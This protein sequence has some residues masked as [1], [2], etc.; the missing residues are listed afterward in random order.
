MAEQVRSSRGGARGTKAARWISRLR[1]L[2]AE[3]PELSASGKWNYV[4][5]PDGPP[6]LTLQGPDLPLLVAGQDA[7][8]VPPGEYQAW[9][10]L[11][12]QHEACR[13]SDDVESRFL[14][15]TNFR[16]AS[17]LSDPAKLIRDRCRESDLLRRAS[18]PPHE[19][20]GTKGR[21][22][23]GLKTLS[24]FHASPQLPPPNQSD[25]EN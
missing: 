11:W 22:G 15:Y 7:G 14:T 23:W 25:S 6:A 19:Q 3:C 12:R 16:R 24:E 21:G 2:L 9:L 13:E 4:A 17:G 10:A 18:I 1:R 8:R 5:R 20:K